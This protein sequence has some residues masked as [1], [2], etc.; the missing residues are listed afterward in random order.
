M[1]DLA[2]QLDDIRECMR[3]RGLWFR[4]HK[5]LEVRAKTIN[6]E[7]RSFETVASTEQPATIFDWR[8]WDLIDEVLVAKGGSFPEVTPLLESHMRYDLGDQLGSARN[9]RLERDQWV[10]RGYI[11]RS[12]TGNVKRDQVWMDIEDGH[13]RAVSIGYEVLNYVDIPAGKRQV[14]DGKTYEARERTLRIS[15]EWRGHELSI[16]SIG[17]DSLA[18]IR[19][20]MGASARKRRSYFR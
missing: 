1:P 18:L 14:V 9:Y 8:S 11:G 5:S 13:V 12:A 15:T 7:D 6:K 2:S 3:E 20:H 16:V 4:D 19:S 17:A 10:A